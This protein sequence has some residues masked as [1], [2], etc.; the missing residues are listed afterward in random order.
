ML[1]DMQ[2]SAARAMLDILWNRYKLE[3]KQPKTIAW[4]LASAAYTI[5]FRLAPWNVL[6]RETADAYSFIWNL[7][8]GQRH[9]A[10]KFYHDI[11]WH[12]HS[13]ET[14]TDGHVRWMTRLT[15][16]GAV[17]TVSWDVHSK[18]MFVSRKLIKWDLQSVGRIMPLIK[19]HRNDLERYMRFVRWHL[20]NTG[21]EAFLRI[22]WM[23]RQ[24]VKPDYDILW[25]LFTSGT[26]IFFTI[27]WNLHRLALAPARTL[28]WNLQSKL[29]FVSRKLV[30][31]DLHDLERTHKS[32]KWHVYNSGTEIFLDITWNVWRKST[33]LITSKWNLYAP[34]LM[35]AHTALWN[36]YKKEQV[37][38]RAIKWNLHGS[39]VF[40]MR[41]LIKWDMHTLERAP[42][43]TFR[44][45]LFNTG[46]EIFLAVKWNLHRLH[47]PDYTIKWDRWRLQRNRAYR[48]YH[49]IR[50]NL[51]SMTHVRKDGHMESPQTRTC[52]CPHLFL[53]HLQQTHVCLR[54]NSSS[55]SCN[56]YGRARP[57]VK[58]Y[59]RNV[60]R[61]SIRVSWDVALI[62]GPQAHAL[63]HI[64]IKRLW[65][66]LRKM[67]KTART[68][69]QTTMNRRGPH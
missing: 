1:W 34:M 30:K 9:R 15:D 36:L 68:H 63:V 40:I 31:W 39:L 7:W 27:K 4:G 19:W 43:R 56:P 32:F 60:G 17:K 23:V 6:K 65:Q 55:G 22:K 25:N 62:K 69:I 26:E 16:L 28:K 37:E 12:L 59:V 66:L 58:W 67:V 41:K 44:W 53:G 64:Q 14:T 52:P 24:T 51:H 5:T 11:E 61:R 45:Q 3:E 50:W 42:V 47:K 18:L 20:Y 21:D 35:P 29:M 13:L 48:F 8:R 57:F 33:R 10:R 38:A 54:A 2:T 49:D 46:D